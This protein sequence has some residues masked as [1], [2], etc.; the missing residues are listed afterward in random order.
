MGNVRDQLSESHMIS[1]Q[2]NQQ[3]SA[4][5]VERGEEFQG[6]TAGI[7][8]GCGTF[9]KGRSFRDHGWDK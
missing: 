1:H 9:R 7:G 2:H 6:I 4:V 3:G 8:K 5:A